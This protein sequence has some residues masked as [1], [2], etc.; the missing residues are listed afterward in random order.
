MM[1]SM[2]KN[3]M[4]FGK[5]SSSILTL[6]TDI[7]NV[8]ERMVNDDE[9]ELFVQPGRALNM[10]P[11][12]NSNFKYLINFIKNSQLR[13][14]APNKR[15]HTH[16]FKDK[17]KIG[18]MLKVMIDRIV[19]KYDAENAKLHSLRIYGLQFYCNEMIV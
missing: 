9:L 18:K 13:S 12:P 4:M 19:R 6:E 16:F 8:E 3:L 10:I 7:L 15:D 2:V 5:G 17:I 14:G 1:A 11:G